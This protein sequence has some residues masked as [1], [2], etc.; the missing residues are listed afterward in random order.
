MLSKSFERYGLGTNE[1]T[2]ISGLTLQTQ[3][4]T[5][6]YRHKVTGIRRR[7]LNWAKRTAVAWE[8]M[9]DG[10]RVRGQNVTN[11]EIRFHCVDFCEY[12]MFQSPPL[13]Q[14]H[15]GA[16]SEDYSVDVTCRDMKC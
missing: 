5:R 14:Q 7:K 12:Y 3:S 13:N 9:G 8:D 2:A 16:E 4:Q 10:T 6:H 11:Q 15:V 1:C